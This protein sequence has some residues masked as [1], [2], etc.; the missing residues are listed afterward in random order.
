MKNW[1]RKIG[2]NITDGY[3]MTEN[4]AICTTLPGDDNKDGTVGKAQP[5]T[6]L[7]IDPETG[8]IQMR[9][10]YVMEGYYKNPEKTAEVIKDGWLCTGDQGRI[11]DDG[12]LYITG[13]VK[14]TFKTT[15][16][17]F[18][19]PSPIEFKFGD[20]KD[21]EQ[22]CIVGR[23]CPQPIGL[24]VASEIGTSKSNQELK[25]S[26]G[27]TLTEVN[28]KL[29]NYKKISTLV[30]TREPWSVE[31]GLLTPTLKVK[32]N[33][34]SQRFEGNLMKWHE[35]NDKVIICL[36]YTS[37]SPRDQRGSRMPSSA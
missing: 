14:D 23:G 10:D 32:R 17:K 9:A 26:L 3:G 11:D 24:V 29:E 35:E 37:P 8:E 1:Y 6:E 12:Y 18:I 15:K 21:I 22:I 5:G 4:C 30:V 25:E 16:G 19:V 13:R 27:T 2:I 34:L 31:N 20:N 7:R 28:N 33:V 36:L